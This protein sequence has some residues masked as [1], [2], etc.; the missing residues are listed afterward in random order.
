MTDTQETGAEVI[1]ECRAD[2]DKMDAHEL[3]QPTTQYLR[4]MLDR[5]ET[6]WKRDTKELRKEIERLK[7]ERNYSGVRERERLRAKGFAIVPKE[8]LERGDAA[9]L[10]EALKAIVGLCAGLMPTWDGAVGQ[11]KDMAE[12]ALAA[13]ARN[14]DIYATVEEA[15]KVW[16]GTPSRD[17]DYLCDW[18]YAT[19]KEMEVSDGSK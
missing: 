14:C 6:A 1:A 16:C 7:E 12:T 19:T 9:K 13:P 8:Q 18:L 15:R 10:R 5:L 17:W 4:I 3:P 2:A 11:I